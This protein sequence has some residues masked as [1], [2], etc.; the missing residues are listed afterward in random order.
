MLDRSREK[1]EEFFKTGK[2]QPIERGEASL[3]VTRLRLAERG[4]GLTLVDNLAA[5]DYKDNLL[6]FKPLEPAVRMTVWLMRPK[7]LTKSRLVE[8]FEQILIKHAKLDFSSN[9]RH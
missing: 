3:S 6:E 1:I 9:L 2:A 7:M 5:N 4:I 8:T